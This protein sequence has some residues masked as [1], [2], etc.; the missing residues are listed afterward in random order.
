MRVSLRHRISEIEKKSKTV[1]DFDVLRIILLIQRERWFFT[2]EN[3]DNEEPCILIRSNREFDNRERD[4]ILDGTFP[5]IYK[6]GAIFIRFDSEFYQIK[7]GNSYDNYVDLTPSQTFNGQIK[8]VEYK[9]VG[10]LQNYARLKDWLDINTGFGNFYF[11]PSLTI[12]VNNFNNLIELSNKDFKKKIQDV[13]FHEISGSGYKARF[14]FTKNLQQSKLIRHALFGDIGESLSK[15]FDL[16]SLLSLEKKISIIFELNDSSI[17]WYFGDN[18]T[19]DQKFIDY[20]KAVI[21]DINEKQNSSEYRAFILKFD[22][23]Q[24]ELAANL[25]NARV[26]NLIKSDKL[27]GSANYTLFQKP[28]CENEVVAL[29]MKLEAAK[30][31]PP[32][33]EINIIEYTSKKGIDALGNF[34]LGKTSAISINAPIEFEFY[35]ESFFEHEHPLEQTQLIICWEAIDLFDIDEI[36]EIVEIND[37]LIKIRVKSYIIPVIFLSKL[38]TFTIKLS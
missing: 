35:L 7:K 4:L 30:L 28:T 25:L 36:D 22:K 12:S 15:Y 34:R 24:K 37:W 3:T 17:E 19:F 18:P 9:T 26:N 33:I 1:P 14:Y 10:L 13:D 29:F 11:K 2:I 38:Y 20:F 6:Y 21:T 32:D 5:Q 8:I 16:T 23:Y 31:L 27:I